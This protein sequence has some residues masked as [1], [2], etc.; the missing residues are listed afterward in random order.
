VA[1]VTLQHPVVTLQHPVV[2]LQHLHH[3][4]DFFFRE[5]ETELAEMNLHF[6]IGLGFGLGLG[7]GSAGEGVR[8]RKLDLHLV[9]CD[10]TAIFCVQHIP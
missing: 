6:I 5:F 2:T 7:F 3:S 8:I 1:V 10:A 9:I 4:T